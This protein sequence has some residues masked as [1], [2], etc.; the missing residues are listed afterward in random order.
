MLVAVGWAGP[1][2]VLASIKLVTQLQWTIIIM[3]SSDISMETLQPWQIFC[4]MFAVFWLVSAWCDQVL[5]T[6]VLCIVFGV[7]GDIITKNMYT[8]NQSES[9]ENQSDQSEKSKESQGY[10]V[11][12]DVPP[13]LPT[14]DYDSGK[15]LDTLSD[16]LE[17]LAAAATNNDDDEESEEEAPV[18]A[19]QYNRTV[20]DEHNQNT[21]NIDFN[22]RETAIAEEDAGANDDDDSD[23]DDND[24]RV[25]R[26]ESSDDYDDDDDM[27]SRE[28]NFNNS[29]NDPDSDDEESDVKANNPIKSL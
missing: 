20:S 27:A 22:N 23:S 10:Q 25:V 4:S 11:E 9:R 5:I 24:R 2:S 28:V 7:V 8:D 26:N 3:T 18:T 12:D 16:K 1:D 13:P 19:R 15:S 6:L 21:S 14:K 29:D 17:A